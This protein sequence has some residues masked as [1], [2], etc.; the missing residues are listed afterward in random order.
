MFEYTYNNK[1]GTPAAYLSVKDA[2]AL[3]SCSEKV[4]RAEITRGRLPSYRVVRLVRIRISDLKQLREQW[5]TRYNQER[6]LQA[7]LEEHLRLCGW[8]W[9]HT[10]NSQRSVAGFPTSSRSGTRGCS[11]PSSRPPRAACPRR[12]VN[13]LTRSTGPASPAY[14]WRLPDDWAHVNRVL[15]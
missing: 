12:N 1:T 6:H 7:V 14:L 2:A 15:K 11:S 10:H 9:Y 13:G 8:R 4:V 5:T 3:L